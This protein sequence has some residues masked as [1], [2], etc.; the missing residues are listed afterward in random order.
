MSRAS[1]IQ[2]LDTEGGLAPTC[3]CDAGHVGATV[4]VNYMAS[5]YFCRTNDVDCKA[6]RNSKNAG[7]FCC[8]GIAGE[9]AR[10]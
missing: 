5:Y 9:L 7:T 2:R 6:R 3:G 1:Q 4:H 10:Q 8:G